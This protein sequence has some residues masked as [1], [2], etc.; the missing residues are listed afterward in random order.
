MTK[1]RGFGLTKKGLGMTNK[2]TRGDEKV[3]SG[4][5][6]EGLHKNIFSTASAIT[7]RVKKKTFLTIY[8]REA[9]DR[10]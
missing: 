2:G 5:Q 1:K 6:Q 3:G 10:P 4:R 9:A 7:S 8:C